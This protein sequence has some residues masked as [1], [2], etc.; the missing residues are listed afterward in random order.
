MSLGVSTSTAAADN[1]AAGPVKT[2]TLA[3]DSTVGTA[4]RG[5]VLEF[6]TSGDNW[7]KYTSGSAKK[8]AVLWENVVL[9]ADG[10]ALCAVTGSEVN[11]NDLDATAKADGE[12][13]AAL[14]GSGIIA[15]AATAVEA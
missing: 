1:L 5:Q 11:R 9:T 2:M 13:V 8:C 7:V 15:R 6:D 10:Y 12:I 14:L 4:V 3:L